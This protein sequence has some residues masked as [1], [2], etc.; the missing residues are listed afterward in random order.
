M[1]ALP[2][3]TLNY[4]VEVP[5]QQPPGLYWYHTHSHGESYV[6]DLDGMSGAIVVEGIDR[7]TGPPADSYAA[8]RSRCFDPGPDGDSNPAMTLAPTE[9]IIF[10]N[11][12]GGTPLM[13][14][15]QTVGIDLPLKVL[16][17]QD[18]SGKSWISYN[19]PTWIAERHGITDAELVV[20]TMT[21]ALSAI[22]ALA[23]SS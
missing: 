17:W 13:Q 18:A 11:A 1:M 9:L 19:E 3:E 10:A 16:V 12:R 20:K 15:I 4:A 23:Y 2:G 21:A 6:Q 22:A 7:V 8:L 14:S 5:P